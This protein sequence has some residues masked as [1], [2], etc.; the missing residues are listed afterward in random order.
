MS[1]P[2]KSAAQAV[3]DLTQPEFRDYEEHKR[4]ID[5]SIA[6]GVQPGIQWNQLVPPLPRHPRSWS[7]W[8]TLRRPEDM[9]TR[10]DG[11]ILLTRGS[12]GVRLGGT[13]QRDTSNPSGTWEL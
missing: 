11:G 5:C 9:A 3:A 2:R 13:S 6:V 1:K 12:M 7:S 4:A 10:A 8:L